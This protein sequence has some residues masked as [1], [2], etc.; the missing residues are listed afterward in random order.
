MVKILRKFGVR[1]D[2]FK[3][4]MKVYGKAELRTPSESIS[5]NGDHRIA[6]SLAILNLF[7]DASLKID[8]VECVDTSYP[9]FWDDLTLLGGRVDR[10][11]K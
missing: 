5:C 1:V 2:E 6:M 8:Q 9:T 4:G 11:C 10:T 7:S 3:D